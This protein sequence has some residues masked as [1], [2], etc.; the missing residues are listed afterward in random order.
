[1]PD[2]TTTPAPPNRTRE[3]QRKLDAAEEKKVLAE[4]ERALADVDVAKAEARKANAEAAKLAAEA[5]TARFVAAKAEIEY[6]R[7]AIKRKKELSANE[8]YNR[9]LFTG[10]VDGSSAQKCMDQLDYWE[11]T[12]EEPG[13]IEIVFF[14]PGGSV[15]AGMNLFDHIQMVRSAGWKI[16]TT[17]RGYAASMG[18]I[19][20]QA[21]DVRAMG[22]ESY[23]HIHEVATMAGGK[24]SEIED[25]I[26]LMKKMESR[27]IDIF[28]SRSKL[29]KARI[30]SGMKRR[31]W[32]I[33]STEALKLGLIDEI[34]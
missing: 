16:T 7:E 32:W 33:D 24:T 2:E 22:A 13:E 17:A 21:G 31:E 4:A 8:F 28:A 6:D 18:G 15:F 1:M 14:S 12:S 5:E 3:D 34:R 11:R 30:K 20:V 29:T 19:L 26:V 23:L 25:E 10:G 27:V 9:Y